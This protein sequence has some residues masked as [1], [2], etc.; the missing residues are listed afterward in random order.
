MVIPSKISDFKF[1]KNMFFEHFMIFRFWILD[2]VFLVFHDGLF[3]SDVGFLILEFCMF[4][5]FLDF[6]YKNPISVVGLPA[7]AFFSGKWHISWKK[8]MFCVFLLIFVE[9]YVYICV[10][11]C[12]RK[13]KQ[14]IV[15]DL[16]GGGVGFFLILL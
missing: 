12:L 3:I 13:A 5:D 7:G 8:C 10:Y 1:K 4:L 11:L 6:V 2:I 9:F 14:A 15:A 16:W